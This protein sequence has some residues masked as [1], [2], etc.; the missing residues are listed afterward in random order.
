MI[1]EFSRL[2]LD[3]RKLEEQDAL[4]IKEFL[5]RLESLH[6]DWTSLFA[7]VDVEFSFLVDKC[8]LSKR[9]DLLQVIT[10][11]VVRNTKTTADF[12]RLLVDTLKENFFTKTPSNVLY[13]HYLSLELAKESPFANQLSF[14]DAL[15]MNA[16]FFCLDKNY[17]KEWVSSVL[18]SADK[19]LIAS[20]TTGKLFLTS[21]FY[22]TVETLLGA[23]FGL[24][25]ETKNRKKRTTELGR[26][27]T[28]NR[29]RSEEARICLDFFLSKRRRLA[30]FAGN[31]SGRSVLEKESGPEYA[32]A[33]TNQSG[34]LLNFVLNEQTSGNRELLDTFWSTLKNCL[35]PNI[36]FL[37][38][39]NHNTCLLLRRVF[40]SRVFIALL[41]LRN[42]IV[43]K[44]A[45]GFS[46]EESAVYVDDF[47]FGFFLFCHNLLPS[48]ANKFFDVANLCLPDRK[49]KYMRNVYQKIRD[50]VVSKLVGETQDE[51]VRKKYH[52]LAAEYAKR[53]DTETANKENRTV[54]EI[55]ASNQFVQTQQDL[56]FFA[57]F[58]RTHFRLSTKSLVL[59]VEDPSAEELVDAKT[60]VKRACELDWDQKENYNALLLVFENIKNVFHPGFFFLDKF[61]NFVHEALETFSVQ[62]STTS[63]WSFVER[64]HCLIWKTL[65]FFGLHS[66]NANLLRLVN[67]NVKKMVGVFT[68]VFSKNDCTPYTSV[69]IELFSF[70]SDFDFGVQHR[71][72]KH[73]LTQL[74]Q[75]D[76]NFISELAEGGLSFN[77]QVLVWYFFAAVDYSVFPSFLAAAAVFFANCCTQVFAGLFTAFIGKLET[78]KELKPQ[79]ILVLLGAL[80]KNNNLAN[81]R[82]SF[83]EDLLRHDS[84]VAVGENK[85][86]VFQVFRSAIE[87]ADQEKA[88]RKFL[89][90][91][92]A[93]GAKEVAVE[94]LKEKLQNREKTKKV[95]V[96]SRNDHKLAKKA[97]LHLLE[98]LEENNK[99]LYLVAPDLVGLI[100]QQVLPPIALQ[101]N[102]ALSTKSK[103]DAFTAEMESVPLVF[104]RKTLVAKYKLSWFDSRLPVVV[105]VFE[106]SGDKLEWLAKH[107]TRVD[108]NTVVTLVLGT[109]F[110]ECAGFFSEKKL[111]FS[112]K[113]CLSVN[114]Y[115]VFGSVVLEVD[116]TVAG[117]LFLVSVFIV[118]HQ[119]PSIFSA[120]MRRDVVVRDA[121]VAKEQ[122]SLFLKE[123]VEK[124]LHTN[125]DSEY[126]LGV[127]LVGKSLLG[128]HSAR[129]R[130]FVRKLF[131]K[132][133]WMLWKV[134]K[135]FLVQFED[136]NFDA[137]SA[138][139]S[140]V[141]ATNSGEKEVSLSELFSAKKESLVAFQEIQTHKNKQFAEFG[142]ELGYHLDLLQLHFHSRSFI[143]KLK[144]VFQTVDRA[145]KQ[146][147]RFVLEKLYKNKNAF[148]VKR[149]V[150]QLLFVS[151]LDK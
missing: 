3:F 67:R 12:P 42:G 105:P 72:I 50:N 111:S 19:Q 138:V 108:A 94:D 136:T 133:F 93:N 118:P 26:E 140:G 121:G 73:S 48:F 147:C 65:L 44:M 49:S 8:I 55:V 131:R 11:L 112:V 104:F 36:V 33:H 78:A 143:A 148:E 116:D 124:E 128:A 58:G 114:N 24:E 141:F 70:L 68:E 15:F 4:H 92:I 125:K 6:M 86:L 41:L 1:A 74:L 54:A 146:L 61:R 14:T 100:E 10:G 117:S 89:Y 127:C 83:L 145:D 142:K 110:K 101:M 16:V 40:L 60:L 46:R 115:L 13:M 149:F 134:E 38:Q 75:S 113:E 53:H 80:K 51:L 66:N 90:F 59:E 17:R 132:D 52:E 27:K 56:E 82:L 30:V 97:A 135:A 47:F 102:L 150:Y 123:L 122:T 2:V 103:G 84:R 5:E 81:A 77:R 87:K 22:K 144:T 28:S 25:I 139:F 20:G 79:L 129:L 35:T 39:G 64:K 37:V 95:Y 120:Q 130:N 43:S 109:F 76:S 63:R 98:R 85:D 119:F 96:E 45:T 62:T 9:T 31:S 21:N 71:S 107:R 29:N 99:G 23:V 34:S 18:E 151:G 32:S 88:R 69:K 7:A 106:V 57:G 126:V 91:L 137:L